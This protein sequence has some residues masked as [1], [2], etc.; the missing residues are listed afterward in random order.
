MMI[1]DWSAESVLFVEFVYSLDS[2][3]NF[4]AVFLFQ[5]NIKV[6]RKQLQQQYDETKNKIHH[7]QASR[8]RLSCVMV[9][10]NGFSCVKWMHHPSKLMEFMP[11][12]DI[13]LMNKFQ[14]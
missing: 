5:T 6:D 2:S 1:L 8:S 11:L 9:L 10:F 7:Y 13:V 4:D 14:L 12:R 3:G